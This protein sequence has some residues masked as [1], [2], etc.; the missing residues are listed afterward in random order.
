M[1]TQAKMVTI[2]GGMMGVGL[3]Y[4][5]AEAGWTDVLLIEKGELT[6]RSANSVAMMRSMPPAG[7]VLR[8]SESFIFIFVV[9]SSKLCNLGLCDIIPSNCFEVSWSALLKVLY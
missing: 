9:S 1:P 2:G 7:S 3:A 4:H 6:R 5:L 8:N